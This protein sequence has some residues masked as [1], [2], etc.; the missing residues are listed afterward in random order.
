MARNGSFS[1]LMGRKLCET[2]CFAAISVALIAPAWAQDAP[3][4]EEEDQI[5]VTGFRANLDSAQNRKRNAD[6]VVDSINA[7]DIGSFPDK[8]VAEALQRVPGVT[9][10]RFA[11][12]DDTS[13]FSA[14]PS[15]VIVRG[16]PQVRSEF[17]GRDTFSANS[18]RGLSWQ[19]ISPEL[20]TGI[21]TYKNQTADM[22]EGGIAGTIN[23]RTRLPLDSEKGVVSIGVVA[24]YGDIANEATPEISGVVSQRFHTGIGEIGVMAN[25]AYSRVKTA[26][27]G[28]QYDRMAIFGAG[29]FGAGKTYI[30]SGIFLRDNLYDRKRFGA[31]GALQWRS[32]DGSAELT[33]QYTRSQYDNSWREHAIYSSA[34]SIYGLP[35]DYVGTDGSV[36]QPLQGTA[37]FTFDD[38]GNF[39]SGWWSAPRPYVGEGDDN[40][41]LG[42]NTAGQAYYNRCYA[43]E[44]CTNPQRAPQ[45]DTAANALRNKQY[46]QDFT[47]NFKWSPSERVH[48]TFDGQ[49]VDSQVHNYNGSVNARTYAN[50]F[51][52]ATGEYPKLTIKNGAA[53]NINLSPNGLTNPNNYSYYSVSDHTED[54]N[55]QEVAFRA[56][57]EYEI[58][59]PWLHSLKVGARYSDRDQTVRWG[60]YNWANISNTWTY[61]QAPYFNLD[62]PVY[63]AGTNET[64]A[65]APDFFNGNQMDNREFVFFDMDKLESREALGKA[66]G[67][68]TIGVG[69]F[70]PV[71]SNAGYRAGESVSGDYGCYLPSEVLKVSEMT[72]A[73][74]AMLKFGG[75]D[76]QIGGVGVSGNIGS[77]L[78]FTVNETAG[79]LTYP[80]GFTPTQLICTR[81]PDPSS[82]LPTATAGCVTS[83]AEIAFAN[84]SYV[85]NTAR[86][87]HLHVLP[88]FNLK[89]DWSSKLVSRFAY[90]RAISRPD[91]GLLRNYTTI[92]RISPN[93]TDRSN[94]DIV[95][96]PDGQ[97][98]VG[99]NWRYTGQAGNPRLKPI[100]AD[101]FDAT[102]EYYFARAGSFTATAFYKKFNNYIQSGRYNLGVTNN[103]VS[104]TVLVTGPMNGNGASIKGAEVAFQ[105]FFDF[106]PGLLSGFGVQANYTYVDNNGIETINLTS[107]NASGTAGGGVSYD[108]TAVKANALEGIS[109]H[110]YNLVG[111][112]EKGPVSARIAYNWRSK[113]LVTAIDCCVGLPIW[114]KSTGYLDASIR[115]RVTR[116]FELSLQG[117]NLLGTDT[118]LY[119]QIDNTGLLKPNAWF[120]NDR[121]I[122]AGIRFT[123]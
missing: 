52:D 29:V 57:V 77:R 111:M 38:E 102:L 123:M 15:G 12:T 67:R 44:G 53:D 71:C 61:T 33:A 31:A 24:N 112:Y 47:L 13:H 22:I 120:K 6:T 116:Q 46:T 19:D 70:Y 81:G 23:L 4:T 16:L 108:S 62:R 49:Y 3:D 50:T 79:A 92:N 55:G 2:A 21:D 51:F 80:T 78:I 117:S 45:L 113:Y 54:S 83:A 56:D 101:Q 105:A 91:V 73:G 74:Y 27:Q 59:S 76:A 98:I 26:S 82:G 88:S 65:F 43:W 114:Q 7:K 14:E 34:F 115:L 25:L 20:L 107:E 10:S 64:F 89:L 8:S 84:G 32:N 39:T 87:D 40:K 109:T 95:F 68:P 42:V 63:A 106:L 35:T 110:S 104:R 100:E 37:P 5:V 17:N 36:V 11:G 60:A 97:T 90:S 93:L 66:L 121:R 58:D 1:S 86:E 122:Q 119:Q 48:L 85:P 18:S 96:G 30:P 99:Y 94:P 28:I 103:G 41:G 9:V 75:G 118:V 69:D 72:T